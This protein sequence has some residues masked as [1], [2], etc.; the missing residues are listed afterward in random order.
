[1][2]NGN[3]KPG[4]QQPGQGQPRPNPKPGEQQPGR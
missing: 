4:E 2:T 1:M 3:P